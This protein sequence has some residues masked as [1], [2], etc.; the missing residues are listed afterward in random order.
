M[1]KKTLP[2]LD[3]PSAMFGARRVEVETSTETQKKKREPFA[4][5]IEED[6]GERIRDMLAA[7]PGAKLT[8]FATWALLRGVE[9]IERTQNNGERFPRRPVRD[10]REGTSFKFGG[11]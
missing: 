4:T 10:L 1:G 3:S 6:L 8:D 11:P 5:Q 2:E 7:L 9:E